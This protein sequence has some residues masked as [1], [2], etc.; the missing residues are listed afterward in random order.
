[1]L[2]PLP[3]HQSLEGCSY[4]AEYFLL[5][6]TLSDRLVVY[7]GWPRS[8]L[9]KIPMCTVSPSS[10]RDFLYS[11]LFFLFIYLFGMELD[12]HGVLAIGRRNGSLPPFAGLTTGI[13]KVWL[14]LD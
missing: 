14:C 11:N 3:R 12:W 1:M 9:R 4:L 7:M 2:T 10:L 6:F 8:V 5:V 13:G